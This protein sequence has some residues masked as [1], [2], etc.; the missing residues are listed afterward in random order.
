MNKRFQYYLIAWA[1][2]LISFCVICF[3]IPAPEGYVKYDAAFWTGFC[4]IIAAM[5]GQLGCSYVALKPDS[6]QRVFY[7]IPL[8]KISYG[9]MV[10]MF[11]AGIITMIL[12]GLPNWVGVVICVLVL[13]FTIIP[14]VKTSAAAEEIARVDEKVAAQ[15]TFIKGLSAEANALM[16]KTTNENTRKECKKVYEA[17]RYSDPMSNERLIG[18]ENR[19]RDLFNELG[20]AVENGEEEKVTEITKKLVSAIEERNLLC[21]TLK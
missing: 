21:K 4:F 2:L 8:I 6:L 3:V 14:L 1:A 20:S 19:I 11:I 18:E 9:G 5:I 13:L 7:N 15:T 17:L 12:P 10:V 16:S